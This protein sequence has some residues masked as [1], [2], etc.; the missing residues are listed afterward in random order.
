MY[1]PDGQ[2]ELS[3]NP[4]HIFAQPI[5][6]PSGNVF[7]ASPCSRLLC[8]ELAYGWVLAQSDGATVGGT[9]LRGSLHAL[10]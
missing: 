7:F 4:S 2:V 6:A 9:G 3:I 5:E 10:T 8:K 1:T